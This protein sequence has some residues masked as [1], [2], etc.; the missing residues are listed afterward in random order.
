MFATLELCTAGA[1]TETS[2][3]IVALRRKP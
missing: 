2:V 1:W 3:A